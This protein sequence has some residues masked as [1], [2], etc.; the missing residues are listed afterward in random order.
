MDIRIFDH[1]LYPE[2]NRNKLVTTMDCSHS[3]MGEITPGTRQNDPLLFGQKIPDTVETRAT[4]KIGEQKFTQ[5][6]EAFFGNLPAFQ[7]FF[8]HTL[9]MGFLTFPETF[10]TFMKL[11]LGLKATSNTFSRN[12]GCLAQ[13]T[14]VFR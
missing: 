13:V 10:R 5:K 2:L 1:F 7:V 12:P 3:T 8:H 11:M 14:G 4:T 6:P 9:P